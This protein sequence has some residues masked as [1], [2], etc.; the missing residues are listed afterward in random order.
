[1][2]LVL[3][4]CIPCLFFVAAVII[5]G[6]ARAEQTA[7]AKL[8]EIER[9]A[10][11]ARDVRAEIPKRPKPAIVL[12]VAPNGSDTNDGTKTHP[13]ATL[14]RARDAIRHIRQKGGL[15]DGGVDVELRGGEYPVKQ[16]FTLTEEDSGTETAPIVYRAHHR[17]TPSFRGGIRLDGFKS[18]DDAAVLARLPEEARAHVVQVNLKTKGVTQLTW[19]S[20]TTQVG[21]CAAAYL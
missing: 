1:M 9:V 4:V 16:T 2:T 19:T 21:G 11:G 12:H 20:P 14:E 13:F 15:P 10:G 5:T 7:A 17:K 18:V 3:R 8:A 6:T